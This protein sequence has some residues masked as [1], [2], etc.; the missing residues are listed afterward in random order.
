MPRCIFAAY[1]TLL[2][3]TDK[4]NIIHAVE[5][6]KLPLLVDAHAQ[7]TSVA[8]GAASSVRC[9]E[10]ETTDRAPRV[11][12]IDAMAIVQCMKTPRMTSIVHLKTTCNARIERMVIGR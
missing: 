5:A 8:S 10:R 12:I 1:G 11:L 2:L 3:P 9:D 6:A 7:S 4:A